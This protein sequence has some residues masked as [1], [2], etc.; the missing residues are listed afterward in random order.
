MPLLPPQ[1]ALLFRHPRL[2]QRQL[3]PQEALL[4]GRSIFR[5]VPSARPSLDSNSDSDSDLL[6]LHSFKLRMMSAA[7]FSLLARENHGNA[8]FYEITRIPGPK[9]QDFSDAWPVSQLIGP[10]LSTGRNEGT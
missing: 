10:K 3:R 1:S 4:P 5:D 9:S 7:A 6:P 2:L 8:G